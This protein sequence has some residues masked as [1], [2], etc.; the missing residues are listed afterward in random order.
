MR[1]LV[2][3]IRTGSVRVMDVPTPRIEPNHVFVR[4][5]ASLIS[6]GTERMVAEFAGK[7]LLRKGL[8]RPDLVR[9]VLDKA[10]REGILTALEVV[11]NRLD[12]PLSL[13]YS[14]AGTVVAVGEQVTDLSVGQRVACGGMG[15]AS[16][17]E[18]VAVPRNLVVPIPD[19]TGQRR[20]LQTIS[21]E[22]AAFTTVG[23]IAVHGLRLANVQLG[24]TLAVLGLG[25]IGLLVV[26]V[27]K[28]AGCV[29]LGMDPNQER[30]RMATTLGCDGTACSS[31]EMKALVHARSAVGAVDAVLITAATASSEPVELAGVISRDRGTIVAVG[32][33]GMDIPRKLYYE[34]ELTFRVSR[35]YGPGR[36]DPAY[37]EKGQDYPLG[38]VR[39]TE[40]RNMQAF[41]QLVAD[42]KVDSKPLVTHRFEIEDAVRAYDLVTGRTE[43]PSLGV[44]IT[45]PDQLALSQRIAL[46]PMSPASPAELVT[47][48]LLGAGQFATSILLPAINRT[49]GVTL[50][51]VCA[52]TGPH[53]RYAGDKFSFQYCTSDEKDILRDPSI[54]TVVIA[55]RHHLHAP[56]V[57]AALDAEKH[58]FCEKPLCVNEGELKAIARLYL[59]HG[60]HVRRPVLMV[61][62]NRRFALLASHLKAFVADVHEPIVMNYRVNA[63]I[64]PLDNWIHDR[65]EGGGRIIGEVCHFVDFLTFLVGAL[66]IRAH[67]RVLPNGGLYQDDNLVVMLEFANHSLGTITYVANGDRRFPKE[68][69]EVF[70]GGVVGVLDDFRKLELLAGGRRRVF[71]SWFYQDKGHLAGWEH[72]V[73]AVK[74][75]AG[76][77]IPVEELVSTSL[78]T[79]RIVEALRTGETVSVDV[80]AFIASVMAEPPDAEAET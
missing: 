60:D 40:N 66:P 26:Q 15:Y 63:G 70:G 5:A 25:L 42:G 39:W 72:F 75:G 74:E 34:K 45:Y 46:R 23:A 69:L 21:F 64:V 48:G 4:V 58:V 35:S 67:V 65:D 56:Q 43:E 2:Q 27:A 17:A 36:Y 13:G 54:N 78:V 47:I 61:G 19:G 44:L 20:A 49:P 16:H 30:C 32:L 6:S 38:Y 79:L 71:R 51:G 57:M 29:V 37:E 9:Q 8:A 14:N 7:G 31:E 55:T 10:R 77:P 11:R 12:R 59:S 62:Y 22:E 28:A 18:F 24:E 1:Q 3:S 53:A 41:L 73:R 76:L 50:V 52:A 80:G 33:T 68:R